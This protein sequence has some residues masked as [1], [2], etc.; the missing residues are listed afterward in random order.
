M[1]PLPCRWTEGH[2]AAPPAPKDVQTKAKQHLHAIWMAETRNAAE[3]AFDHFID[4]H[5]AKYDKAAACL[6]RDR[7]T[8]LAFYDFS[9]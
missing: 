8:L 5:G 2:A 1:W 6:V 4:A 9:G 3:A 7:E